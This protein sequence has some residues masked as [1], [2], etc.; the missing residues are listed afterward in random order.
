MNAVVRAPAPHR[1]KVADVRLMVE[2]GVFDA[3]AKLELL[4]GEL[5]D[6]PSD[7]FVHTS[8]KALL[9]RHFNRALADNWLVVPDSTLHLSPTDAPHPDLLVVEQSL[10][11]EP[12][13]PQTIALL[14][15]VANTSLSHDLGRKAVKYAQY[16]LA[17]YWVTDVN[18]RITTVHR[19]PVLGVYQFKDDLPFAERLTPLR[20]PEAGVVIAD[21]V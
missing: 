13:D 17:E 15:E 11:D 5:I 16:G 1:F 6:M 3:R 9:T 14:I 2:R 7:G 18:A 4:D 21:L 19:N 8:L 10:F 20:L 12:V